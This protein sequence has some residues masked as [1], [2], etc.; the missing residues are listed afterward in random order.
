M[1]FSYNWLKE[2]AG[3]TESPKELAELL[4]MHVFE[5]ESIDKA[6]NDHCLD[7]AILPNRV[8]DASG[9]FGLA[10]EIAAI[11]KKSFVPPKVKVTPDTAQRV[12]KHLHVDVK[13][14]KHCPDRKSVV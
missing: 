6:G 2:L 5:V 7:V 1:K 11:K 12:D 9:H 13:N 4:T 10:R 8:S 3:F 14:P